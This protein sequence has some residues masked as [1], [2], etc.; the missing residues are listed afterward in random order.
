MNILGYEILPSVPNETLYMAVA[1]LVFVGLIVLFLR[2]KKDE[3]YAHKDID[4]EAPKEF[5]DMMKTSA[6]KIFGSKFFLWNGPIKLGRI[7]AFSPISWDTK[8]SLEQNLAG[9]SERKKLEDTLKE[10]KAVADQVRGINVPQVPAPVINFYCFEVIKDNPI[11]KLLYAFGFGKNYHIVD[12]KLCR[13]NYHEYEVNLYARP[14]H[15]FKNVYVYGEMAKMYALNI[16][17]KLTVHQL[18]N[19][20]V[21]YVVKMDYVEMKT[22]NYAARAREYSDIKHTGWQ[23][24]EQKLRKGD[25]E[26]PPTA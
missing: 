21:N 10:I 25:E 4:V 17:D 22:A 24:G 14:K 23:R 12:K 1:A 5:K 19:A 20:I 2:R 3:T 15:E 26:G 9:R 7:S 16:A 11:A 6:A 18:C 13:R 8:L